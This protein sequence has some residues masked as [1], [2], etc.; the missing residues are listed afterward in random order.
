MRYWD[1][2][3]DEIINRLIKKYN[4]KKYLEIGVA[5]GGNF[6]SIDIEFKECVDP[7]PDDNFKVTYQMTSD[8]FFEKIAPT[9]NYKYDIIFID[10]L[11]EFQQVDKDLQNSLQYLNENGT[12]VL[13]DCCPREEIVQRVPQVST[14]YWT[15]DVWKTALK[16]RMEDNDLRLLVVDTDLG[17]GVVRKGY[18]QKYVPDEK[19][20]NDIYSYAH[21]DLKRK[22]ILNLV[23]VDEFKEIFSL[24]NTKI[25]LKSILKDSCY[26]TAGTVTTETDIELAEQYILYNKDFISLFPIIVT[27]HNKMNGGVADELLDKYNQLWK[28]NFPNSHVEILKT[29]ENRGHTF[30]IFDIENRIFEYTLQNKDK[31]KWVWKFAFDIICQPDIL[32]VEVDVADFYYINNIGFQYLV[33]NNLDVDICLDKINSKEYFY[34]QTPY[35]IMRNDIDELNDSVKY[36]KYYDVF[37]NRPD[38]NVRPWELIQGCDCEAFLKECI[39]RNNLKSYNLLHNNES[40]DLLNVTLERKIVDGSLKNIMFKRLGNLC[41]FQYP[42]QDVIVI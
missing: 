28:D 41:H 9:L 23:S 29:R 39:T 19:F 31:I 36:N 11:H 25:K 20:E 5:F 27:S 13:H 10:G 14:N 18:Q 16:C 15:G 42:E 6:K 35:Y 4:Y 40:K 1:Y 7:S 12:I 2:E 26:A 24:E 30:G 32:E 17:V 8:E 21:L 34:P 33:D 38:K 3:R 22:E 37:V